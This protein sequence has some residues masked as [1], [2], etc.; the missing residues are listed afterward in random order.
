M[1]INDNVTWYITGHL[2]YPD[3]GPHEVLE[4]IQTGYRM[5]Q[6]PHCSS[7][8]YVY[9]VHSGSQLVLYLIY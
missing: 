3:M 5:S 8:L 6:P 1:Y 9:T 4:K 7:D 2:P